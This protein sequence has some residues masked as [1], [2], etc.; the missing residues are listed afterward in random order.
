MGAGERQTEA[1]AEAKAAQRESLLLRGV[2]H[3]PARGR[4]RR[5]LGRTWS[6][7]TPGRQGREGRAAGGRPMRAAA[8]AEERERKARRG[9]G[10]LPLPRPL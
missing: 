2:S 6:L 9:G 10:L 4:Q 8:G 3:S 5:G 7:Q 1:E